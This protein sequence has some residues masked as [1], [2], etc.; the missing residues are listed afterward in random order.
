MALVLSWRG[1]GDR[2]GAAVA[3]VVALCSS[4]A[5]NGRSCSADSARW[6]YKQLGSRWYAFAASGAQ[7]FELSIAHVQSDAYAA[8]SRVVVRCVAGELALPVELLASRVR[9]V[10]LCDFLTRRCCATMRQFEERAQNSSSFGDAPS[11]SGSGWAASKGGDLR[12]AHPGACILEQSSLQLLRADDSSEWTLEARFELGLP[13]S[14]RTIE[15]RKAHT[16]LCETND[17][18]TKRQYSA[19][20][21]HEHVICA[22][23]QAALRGMPEPAGLVAF[24]PY[25]AILP[26]L[27]GASE[28]PMPSAS[29]LPFSSPDVLRV[30]AA[31]PSGKTL[32]GMGIRKGVNII[33]GGGFHGKSTPL[34]AIELG[35]YNHVP[36][37][38][39][40]FVSC[41]AFAS[42]MRA[43]DGRAV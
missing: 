26:R 12:M 19:Q 6:A 25:V 16:I 8:R 9:R 15:G 38:G 2:R 7:R 33:V 13:A 39:R 4:C 28:L 23:D 22:E 31:L 21:A 20:A 37:D 36:G 11:S 42:K 27:H 24:V 10:A 17:H 3:V 5:T 35:V 41:L 43:E 18:Q 34:Q 14:G 32:T 29:A 30:S 40:E 1:G